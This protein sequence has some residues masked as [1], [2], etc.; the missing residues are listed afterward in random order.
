MR[1]SAYRCAAFR[2]V[3]ERIFGPVPPRPLD[4]WVFFREA[5]SPW[6]G[7]TQAGAATAVNWVETESF[8][9]HDTAF[10]L[11]DDPADGWEE[12]WALQA[13]LYLERILRQPP[14]WL[15]QG[16]SACLSTADFARN[17]DL[18]AGRLDR[19]CSRWLE[20]MPAMP[21]AAFF[22]ATYGFV[23]RPAAED[24]VGP[25]Y[26]Q[27]WLVAHALL[28]RWE[29]GR[30]TR[31]LA[32][33]CRRLHGDARDEFRVEAW[34]GLNPG[35]LSAALQHAD[36]TQALL[37]A[38]NGPELRHQ[39]ND[40][41]LSEAE[42]DATWYDVMADSDPLRAAVAL[43]AAKRLAPDSPQVLAS[44]ARQALRAGD[45]SGAANFYRR[46]IAAGCENGYAYYVSARQRLDDVTAGRGE[47]P[48]D[49]GG[50]AVR[51][52][53]ELTRALHL[54]PDNP[55][56]YIQL[57]RALY[58]SPKLDRSQIGQVMPGLTDSRSLQGVR[59]Y[60]GLINLRWGDRPG[61]AR[62]FRAIIADPRAAPQDRTLA[63]RAL[64]RLDRPSSDRP[65]PMM[66]AAPIFLDDS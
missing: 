8:G 22:R 62:E 29:Q 19:R 28:L 7:M 56:I 41:P 33:L 42:R 10:A 61:A 18:A 13:R 45:S 2:Q 52:V 4:T 9:C 60:L 20:R 40:V 53:A 44:E 46:A 51:A 57:S 24:P 66:A 65:A 48:G 31:D 5:A 23:D 37:I 1:D 34:L 12:A 39:L 38:V 47:I 43:A 59:Y 27:A 35:G 50:E 11:D 63:S 58:L 55:L 21:W 54:E 64:A 36:P 30:G 17:G 6:A 14:G 26:T 25:Y 3:F 49:G 16:I 15:V 32:G